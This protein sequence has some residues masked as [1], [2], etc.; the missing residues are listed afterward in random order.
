MRLIDE[1]LD[2]SKVERVK[3][4]IMPAPMHL[5]VLQEDCSGRFTMLAK[6]EKPRL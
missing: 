4:E 6:K 3:I 1:I 2:L 5:G